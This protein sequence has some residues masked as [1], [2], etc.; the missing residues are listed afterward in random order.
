MSYTTV[1]AAW[2][3]EKVEDFEE[4][5][6]GYGSAPV[7]WNDM[8]ECMYSSKCNLL[9]PLYKDSEISLHQRAVLVMTYDRALVFKRDYARAAADIRAYLKDFPGKGGGV[10]HWPRIA[11]IFESDPDVPAIGFQ[12]TSVSDDL[13]VG[14]WDEGLQGYAPVDWTPFYSVYEL[15]DKYTLTPETDAQ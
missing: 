5:R 7:I 8:Y 14:D 3:G 4:L 10:N 13:F 2:P 11:E 9:W 1:K 6:N 12:M 15:L